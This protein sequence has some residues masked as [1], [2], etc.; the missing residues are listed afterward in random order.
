MKNSI[1]QL[2]ERIPPML[3]W[4]IGSVF[5]A[6]SGIA[7]ADHLPPGTLVIHFRIPPDYMEKPAGTDIY[8][9][10][11]ID[12]AMQLAKIGDAEAQSNLGVMYAS[13]GEYEQAAYW[14]K[15]AA[16]A[17][18]DTA[19]YNLGTLYFNGQG[20]SKDYA[21]AHMFFEQAANRGNRYAEFQLG[22]TYFTG[23]GVEKDPAKE[24]SWYE[25]AARQGLPAAQYNLAV[26]YFNGEGVPQDKVK[27]YAWMLQAHKGGLD[28]DSQEALNIMAKSMTPEQIQSAEK[29]SLSLSA[30]AW[31]VTGNK[32][33]RTIGW[34][35]NPTDPIELSALQTQHY[36]IVGAGWAIH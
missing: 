3:P 32:N 29:L 13:R 28:A 33:G 1:T 22:M 35:R 31:S 12:S 4:I 8:S 16:D 17:G 34:V 10:K 30:G 20:V 25:R 5:I 9:K 23:Q 26:N 6:A 11:D 21:K 14:Y 15:Q 7:M 36:Y 2:I 18:L 19:A 27:A 24:T